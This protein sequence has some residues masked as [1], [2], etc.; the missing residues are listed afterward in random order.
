MP[1]LNAILSS[2]TPL[3]EDHRA[4]L[5]WRRISEKPT[6]ITLK[7]GAATLDP[8]TM[9]VENSEASSMQ[10]GNAGTGTLRD[11]VLFGVRNHPDV[12]VE[13]TDVQ[14]KD[15]FVLNNIEYQVMDIVRTLGEVQAR[16][17]AVSS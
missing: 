12:T 17:E 5:A 8:Q 6:T 4:A 2:G 13:D 15:R 3:D 7:R 1:D 9:R 11:V 10:R 14:A 16:A